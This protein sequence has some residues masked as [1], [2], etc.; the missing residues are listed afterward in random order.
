MDLSSEDALRLNVML[1]NRPQAIRI[2]ES[3]MTVH[4]L[5]ERGEAE[6]RLNPNCRDERYVRKVRELLSGHVLGSPGG[7]PIYLKRWTR[8]GQM[9]DESLD[10]LLLLGE[11]EAVVAAVCA[12]GLTDE[13]AR[14]AWWIMQD[15]EN[16]R[17]MLA[18]PRIAGGAMGPVLA[19]YLV[20]HLPFETEPELM[21]ETVRL[22]L[23][24][25]LIDEAG[26]AELWKRAARKNAY[27]VGF[28]AATPDDL[29]AEVPER[30]DRQARR[31]RLAPL[32]HEGNPY[33]AL[34]L[35]AL[36]AEGQAFL[37]TVATVFRKP[38]NQEVVSTTLDLVRGY[39]SPVRPEGDPDQTVEALVEEAAQR[40]RG[41]TPDEAMAAVLEADPDL[42]PELRALRVLSGLGYGVVR[43]ALGGT[44]AIG[45]LMRRKL[46]PV[47]GPVNEQ[48]RILRGKV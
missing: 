17:R 1:A 37:D 21:I 15:S 13:Q 36:A 48:I 9:R 18:N 16:A 7:Y 47:L 41:E 40:S 6:I 3:A 43:P 10:Q 45:S 42:A 8:M 44:D 39:C 46:E 20:E 33:A 22:V 4:A 30:S 24:P 38:A 26:R 35:K 32:R 29:P 28:L 27:F 23:Q 31:A 14:R 25:G 34:L 5:S 19:E 11:P 2:N 12:P